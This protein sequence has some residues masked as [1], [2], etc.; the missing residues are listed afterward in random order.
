MTKCP[1]VRSK[2]KKILKVLKSWVLRL[3][4]ELTLSSQS[5]AGCASPGPCV[6]T[7]PHSQMPMV[8][9]TLTASERAGALRIKPERRKIASADRKGIQT[10]FVKVTHSTSLQEGPVCLQDE[11]EDSHCRNIRNTFLDFSERLYR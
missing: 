8:T 4:S 3:L 6:E 11:H 7:G 9:V 5:R 1:W 10:L 2:K